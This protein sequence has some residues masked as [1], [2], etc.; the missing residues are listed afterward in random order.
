[1]RFDRLSQLSGP[2]SFASFGS[3]FVNCF[4]ASYMCGARRNASCKL[5][6][7]SHVV[8]P[9]FR[10]SALRDMGRCR[11]LKSRRGGVQIAVPVPGAVNVLPRHRPTSPRSTV[12]N[13]VVDI[14]HICRMNTTR[15]RLCCRWY[16]GTR[17]CGS[18]RGGALERVRHLSY[19]PRP[20]GE[21]QGG[22]DVRGDAGLICWSVPG[23]TDGMG[24]RSWLAIQETCYYPI[25]LV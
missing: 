10:C 22:R 8:H 5:T 17:H 11:C 15:E 14:V 9:C 19:A 7:R 13:A 1:M 18:D 23:T 3:A 20:C 12:A 16:C 6:A 21:G 24:G 4:S 25:D 2:C